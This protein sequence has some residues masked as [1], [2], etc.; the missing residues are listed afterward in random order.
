M[1]NRSNLI[2]LHWNSANLKQGAHIHQHTAGQVRHARAQPYHEGSDSHIQL[3]RPYWVPPAWQS[4]WV[5]ERERGEP[6]SQK[7]RT[8]EV[9]A[10]QSIKRQLHTTRGSCWLGTA[11]QSYHDMRDEGG[12]R[13]TS[14]SKGHTYTNPRPGHYLTH[15]HSHITRAVSALDSCFALTGAHQHYIT[16]GQWPGKTRV[17]FF[18]SRRAYIA[19]KNTDTALYDTILYITGYNMPQDGCI[20]T[21]KV[22][23]VMGPATPYTSTLLDNH[24]RGQNSTSGQ[25]KRHERR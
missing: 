17:F 7:P 9:C 14:K 1:K 13:V 15:A 12:S 2:R 6:T 11:Q 10:K 22:A 19:T 23:G 21:P 3:F 25:V 5:N 8:A 18:V 16:V 24:D 4:C 20:S